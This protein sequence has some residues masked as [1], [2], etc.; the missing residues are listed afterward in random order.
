MQGVGGEGKRGSRQD[1]GDSA[2]VGGVCVFVR[3]VD[4]PRPLANENKQNV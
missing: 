1:G 3:V 2:G 4:K